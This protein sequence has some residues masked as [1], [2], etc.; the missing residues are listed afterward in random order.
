MTANHQTDPKRRPVIDMSKCSMCRACID[1]C[2]VRAIEEP[3]S[4]SCAK[5]VQYCQSMISPCKPANLVICQDRCDGCGSCIA[6]CPEQAIVWD[7][8]T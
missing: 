6:A 8:G 4:F 3:A 5:C 7:T 2:P 1:A